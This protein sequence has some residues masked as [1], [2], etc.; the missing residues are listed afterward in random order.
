M[1]PAYVRFTDA[2]V[3]DLENIFKKDPQ[4]VRQV[5]KKCLLLERS[6]YAGEELLGGLIGFRRLVVGDRDWRIVWRVT[7]GETISIDVSEIWAVGTRTKSEVYTEMKERIG[8]MP[9][10]TIT[11]SLEH[12]VDLL[13]P[14]SGVDFTPEQVSDPVPDWLR[15]RLIH[16]AGLRSDQLDGLTGAEAA[17]L[18]DQ[19]MQRGSPLTR[20]PRII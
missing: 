14:N 5:L 7:K 20:S 1:T 13:T 17:D 9:D 16:T 3:E 15:Q 11:H 18:W 10:S 12:V 8:A 19:Y 6:P 2:A 4:I